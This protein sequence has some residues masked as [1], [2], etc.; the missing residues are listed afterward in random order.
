[1]IKPPFKMG[2]VVY[3][4]DAGTLAKVFSCKLAGGGNHLVRV[5][6]DDGHLLRRGRPVSDV[7][8]LYDLRGQCFRDRAFG[9]LWTVVSTSNAKKSLTL[10]TDGSEKRVTYQV[11][12]PFLQFFHGQVV[13]KEKR[14][15][16]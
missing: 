1:V 2:D 12:Y 7:V 11:P 15:D 3:V 8:R 16:E 14:S 13:E 6:C 10:E 9:L 5:N 4:P